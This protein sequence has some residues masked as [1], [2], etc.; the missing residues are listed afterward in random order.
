MSSSSKIG[1]RISPHRINTG[2]LSPHRTN[3]HRQSTSSIS[4]NPV[5]HSKSV[6]EEPSKSRMEPRLIP[7][8]NSSK[9]TPELD[10]I[11]SDV[12]EKK[13]KLMDN[14]KI[15]E[16][17]GNKFEHP[18]CLTHNNILGLYCM[19]EKIILCVNC[20]Y[21]VHRHRSHRVVPLQNCMQ[22]IY[23]D[24]TELK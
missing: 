15:Y 3:G 5:S 20:L 17:F 24:N 13:N 4:K 22:N 8:V 16:M 19:N 10:R 23:S 12:V 9:L 14:L 7:S 1:G 6:F 2:Q 21:G 11:L 18:R